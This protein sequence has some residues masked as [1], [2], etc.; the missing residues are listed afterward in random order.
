MSGGD[1]GRAEKAAYFVKLI[2]LLDEYNKIFLVGVDN[3]GSTQM[4]KIRRDI[5]GKGVVLMGKN[6]MIRK[7][8]RGHTQ[9]NPSL[10]NLL[11]YVKG[12]VGFVFVKDD[13]AGVKKLLLE[14]KVSA[15]AKVGQIAPQDVIVP[16]GNTGLEPTQTSFFQAL[17]IQT[18]INKGQI[19]IVNDVHLIKVG[20]R[21]GVSESNLLTKLDIKPFKWGLVVNNVFD[22]GTVYSPSVID[23]TDDDLIAK[24]RNGVRNIASLGLQIGYP[25]LASLPHSIAR[26][27]KNI[28][29]ISLAVDYP[30]K[31]AD[32][33]RNMIA[34]P[35]AFVQQA[36][37]KTEKK[38]EKV[39]VEE[40]KPEKKV[41]SDEDG[42]M[43][44]SL[45]D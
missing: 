37:A 30:I 24:F 35:Q 2:K 34:N 3:V 8:I 26:G 4:Q 28:V 15:P 20:A 5:R 32:Q 23:M 12:N 16:K 42:D 18:K 17:N 21:V 33:I 25:T 44:L 7:A 9:N 22:A 13:L 6:T 27:F 11:P 14:N 38:V 39:E 29:S 45:F 1:S 40:K 10:E 19:E 31:Q 43:G 36:P 41:E